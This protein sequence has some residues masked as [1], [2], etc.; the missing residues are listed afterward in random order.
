MMVGNAG[1]NTPVMQVYNR[2]VVSHFVIRKNRYVKS[3][4]CFL[5][6]S[7][8]IE[9]CFILFSRYLMWFPMLISGLFRTNDMQAEFGI[10]IFVYG[11]R[12]VIISPAC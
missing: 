6:A 1:N 7:S 8:A 9:L 3:V 5:L 2:A 4:H 10:H 11:C 12:T